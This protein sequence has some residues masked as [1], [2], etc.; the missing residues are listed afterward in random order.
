MTGI[1]MV[2]VPYKGPAA[3]LID[4]LSGQVSVYFVNIMSGLP[5]VKSGKLRALGVTTPQRSGIAPELPAIAEAGLKAFD[6]TN[7]YGLLVPAATPRQTIA[8]LEQEIK[9]VMAFAEFQSSLAAVGMTPVASSAE[10]FAA[11]L[12][13]EMVKYAQVVKS[14]GVKPE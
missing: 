7:W 5:Y 14:A 2:H 12:A 8:R 9:R 6:M 11:F 1:K 3:A 10:Q 13:R 4:L